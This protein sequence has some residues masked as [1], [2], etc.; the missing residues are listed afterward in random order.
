MRLDLT[1]LVRLDVGSWSRTL[2]LHVLWVA[3]SSE[4]FRDRVAQ[5]TEGGDPGLPSQVPAAPNATK[6]MPGRA[7][8]TVPPLAHGAVVSPN[9]MTS[10]YEDFWRHQQ[11]QVSQTCWLLWRS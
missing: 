10:V 3:E 1:T 9:R 11:S 6:S 5:R 4:V 8:G 7:T 2:E